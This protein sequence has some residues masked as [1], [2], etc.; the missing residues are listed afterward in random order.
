LYDYPTS[1]VID[2]LGPDSGI[3]R[4]CRGGAYFNDELTTRVS[5]RFKRESDDRFESV[6]F[7]PARSVP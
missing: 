7:R 5:I 3:D 2:P 4:V 1:K 6:G